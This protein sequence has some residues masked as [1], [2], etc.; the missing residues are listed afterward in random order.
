MNPNFIYLLIGIN[1]ITVTLAFIDKRAAI[2]GARRI[3]ERTLLLFAALGGSPGLYAS[4]YL[5]HHKTKHAKF[6]IG[7]PLILLIQG[8]MLWALYLGK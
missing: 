5:F 6:Y 3:S 2:R 1:F 8:G 7:V 4:M